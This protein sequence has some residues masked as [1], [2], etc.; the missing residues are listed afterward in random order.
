[1]AINLEPLLSASLAIQLHVYTVVPAFFLG[2]VQMILPK[3][4]AIHRINGGVF[5]ALMVSTAIIAFFIPSFMGA[6]FSF[7]HLFIPLT[8]FTVP[9]ALV[10]SRRENIKAHRN[11]MIGLYVGALLIAGLLSFMPGRVMFN[12]FFAG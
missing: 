1:M 9:R 11:A 2:T 7:I 5:M 10:A 8:L 6:R 4:T 12:M 3:G